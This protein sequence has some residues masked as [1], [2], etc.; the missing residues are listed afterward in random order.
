LKGRA[1]NA[2][3]V[4]RNAT[5]D[6]KKDIRPI[7][8]KLEINDREQIKTILDCSQECIYDTA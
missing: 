5:I 3:S 1:T 2:V 8:R 6:R 7:S 4:P